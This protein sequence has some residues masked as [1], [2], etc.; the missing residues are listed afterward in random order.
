MTLNSFYYNI[1]PLI[2]RSL[3]IAIRRIIAKRKRRIYRNV[4]PINPAAGKK[5][6][7]FKGW[8]DNKKFA[9]VIQHDV[10]TQRG[11][12][13]C[14]KLMEVEKELGIRSLFSFVPEKY[15]VSKSLLANIQKEGFEVSVHGL[16][17]DGK[18]FFSE[19]IFKERAVKIN[20]YLKEWN[21]RGF[22]APSMLHN[23][24]WMHML[25]IDYCT[26]T[27]DTDPFEP[28]PEGV[29][30]VFPYFVKRKNNHRI[31]L[32]LPYTLPQD[33][34]L[35]IILKERGIDT[36]KNKL[37]WIVANGGMALL[38]S[39]P[40]YMD[41]HNHVFKTERYPANLYIEFI[42]YIQTKYNGQF[43][44]ALP[45]NILN[46]WHENYQI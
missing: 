7:G 32:E 26:S 9:L 34:L 29:N 33:H 22:T 39:H 30:T 28:Q 41:F 15:N 6:E 19:A 18:L 1:K 3:Q 10:D 24:E 46:Y 14:Y 40:D 16:K 8:P 23:E 11:H 21:S 2:P 43:W 25:D 38:N 12:D 20:K 42:Q 27:F 36:W 4:W 37:D 17:H 13:N 45:K 35:F 44:Q 5:P 31:Y